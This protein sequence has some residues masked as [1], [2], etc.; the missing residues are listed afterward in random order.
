M[1]EGSFF[2]KEQTGD[3]PVYPGHPLVLA[4]AIMAVFPDFATASAPTEHGWCVA[5][6]DN[7]I[8]GAGDHVG[9][10][11]RCL[12]IGAKG[13]TAEEMIEYASRYWVQGNAGGHH[14]AVPAGVEQATAI[15]PKFRE[16][17][18][19]WFKPATAVDGSQPV[20]QTDDLIARCQELIGK[21]AQVEAVRLY[22]VRH[23]CGLPKALKDLGLR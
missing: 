1:E 19:E 4:T 8:P 23:Q 11:V 3:W 20:E 15:E 10:A 13:G 6:G 7:R 5:L 16:L 17:A 21:G 2:I 22:R 14:T 18:A 12:A 9:A